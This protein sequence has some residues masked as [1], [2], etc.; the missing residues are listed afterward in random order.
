MNIFYLP[1]LAGKY[2]RIDI[3]VG[4]H[5]WRGNRIQEKVLNGCPWENISIVLCRNIILERN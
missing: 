3:D 5:L 2:Y 1:F 4:A